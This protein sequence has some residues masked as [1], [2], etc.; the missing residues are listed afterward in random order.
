ML[1]GNRRD[2]KM[3]QNTP[4]LTKRRENKKKKSNVRVKKHE[5]QKRQEIMRLMQ[6]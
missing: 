3:P 4:A 1:P 5:E 6:K 2:T